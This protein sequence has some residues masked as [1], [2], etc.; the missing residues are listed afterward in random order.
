MEPNYLKSKIQE[1]VENERLRIAQRQQ[2]CQKQ[3]NHILQQLRG[4]GI[5]PKFDPNTFTIVVDTGLVLQCRGFSVK[6]NNQRDEYYYDELETL[7]AIAKHF[8]LKA[9]YIEE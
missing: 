4:A 6:Y 5:N 3:F 2:A 1:E 8:A 9:L 7:N